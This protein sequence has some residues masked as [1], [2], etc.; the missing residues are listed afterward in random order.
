MSLPLFYSFTILVNVFSIV[1][2]GPKLLYMDNIPLWLAAAIS[3]GIS[4]FFMVF[5][6]LVV[7]PWQR[8]KILREMGHPKSPVNFNIGESSDTSPEGS[9]KKSNRN[10]ALLERQLTVISE[11]TELQALDNRITAAKY[12]FPIQI[13]DKNGYMPPTET[14]VQTRPKELKFVESTGKWSCIVKLS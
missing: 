5:I 6:W 3:V 9:P 4:L 11:N 12:M 1:H 8:R 14:E 7:V 2:D 13:S 10:S